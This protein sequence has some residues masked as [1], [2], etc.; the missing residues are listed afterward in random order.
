MNPVEALQAVGLNPIVIDGADD[1]GRQLEG[2][3][4]QRETNVEFVTRIMEFCPHGALGQAFVMEAL[5]AYCQL[6]KDAPPGIFDN[7]LLA[8][9]VW[10]RVGEWLEGELFA[11]HGKA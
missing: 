2:L 10:L 9:G 11:R 6:V 1:L 7:G 4:R 5:D 3:L 8:E